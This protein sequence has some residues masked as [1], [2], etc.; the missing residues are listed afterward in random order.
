M[1]LGAY[2]RR[3]ARGGAHRR[4]T[5]LLTQHRAPPQAALIRASLLAARLARPEA[6]CGGVLVP[7]RFPTP[8]K[9]KG[10][11]VQRRKV[12]IT[13]PNWAETMR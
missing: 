11:A 6:D 9:A 1:A 2:H 12:C 8:A 3:R 10:L 7:P 4:R 5:G 13:R